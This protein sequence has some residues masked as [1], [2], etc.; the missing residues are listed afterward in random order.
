MRQ[1]HQVPIRLLKSFREKMF[2]NFV[3][4]LWPFFQFYI[5]PV[6]RLFSP[7]FL[8]REFFWCVSM[9]IPERERNVNNSSDGFLAM[10]VFGLMKRADWFQISFRKY[11]IKG[12]GVAVQRNC[13]I[14]QCLIRANTNISGFFPS[15]S[16]V[17]K[18]SLRAI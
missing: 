17:A 7:L 5:V 13:L 6:M 14:F 8:E 16:N 11:C 1:A 2:K 9:P 4:I 3:S 18:V 12:G 15:I 10:K